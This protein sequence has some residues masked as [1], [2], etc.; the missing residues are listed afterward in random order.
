MIKKTAEVLMLLFFAVFLNSS[1]MHDNPTVK[2]NRGED[3]IFLLWSLSDIQPR[4]EKE[5]IYFETAIDD[6]NHNIPGVNI[7]VFAGD[8]IQHSEFD[9]IFNWYLKTRRASRVSEW[10]EIAGNHE[11]R[12]IDLYKKYINDKLNYSLERG[13]LLLLFMSNEKSGRKTFISN[14]TFKWWEQMVQNN[15]D[16]I[17]ITV[18]HGALEGSGLSASMLDRLAIIDSERFREV[19][20]KY[21]VDIW[22]SGHSHF[23]G[24][25]P[26]MFV[27]NRELGGTAFIDNGAIRKDFSTA[28][29]SRFLYFN[30]GSS[31]A[32]VKR[33]NHETK[34]FSSE[35]L[36]IPLSHPFLKQNMR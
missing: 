19:L 27:I 25:F 13:N 7:A 35:N 32:V 17:I 30:E 10:F 8:I 29:E 36:I 28:V 22:I 33:R 2:D 14:E 1:C 6:V 20:K 4:T 21:R 31:A 26:R 15:Q 18:T 16:R 23:P 12:A 5:K 3:R 34:S 24:W 11:W 9:D